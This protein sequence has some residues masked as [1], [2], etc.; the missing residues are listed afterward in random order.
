MKNVESKNLK[1]PLDYVNMLKKTKTENSVNS[2]KKV[3]FKYIISRFEFLG[4]S[5]RP[6]KC[7]DQGQLYVD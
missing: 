2:N 6:N 3:L 7:S 5:R 1:Y 4:S